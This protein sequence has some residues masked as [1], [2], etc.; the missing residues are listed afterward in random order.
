[1]STNWIDTDTLPL[2]TGDNPFFGEYGTNHCIPGIRQWVRDMRTPWYI[3]E[4][5]NDVMAHTH[6]P[7]GLV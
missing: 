6:I 5:R 7:P 2:P 4:M 3:A 1:M